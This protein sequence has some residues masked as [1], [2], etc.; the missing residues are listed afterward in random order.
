MGTLTVLNE[1]HMTIKNQKVL[2]FDD[3]VGELHRKLSELHDAIITLKWKKKQY[4]NEANV[5]E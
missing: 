1:E 3:S 5:Y 2:K 4:L